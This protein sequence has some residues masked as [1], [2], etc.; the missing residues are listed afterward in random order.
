MSGE[1]HLFKLHTSYAGGSKGDGIASATGTDVAYSLP[2]ELG[3]EPGRTN[4][5]QLLLASVAACYSL[6]LSVL[7]ERKRLPFVKVEVNAEGAV[8]VQ[9]GGTLKYT[10]IKLTPT[11]TMDNADETQLKSMEDFAHKAELYCP[12]SGALRGNVEVTVEPNIING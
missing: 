6:T 7:A 11:I 2:P 4:P 10:S 8:I 5:E 12:I 1:T 9:P 3:G